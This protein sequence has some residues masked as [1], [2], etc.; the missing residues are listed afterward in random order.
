MTDP[1]LPGILPGESRRRWRVRATQAGFDVSPSRPPLEPVGYSQQEPPW[2]DPVAEAARLRIHRLTT[3]QQRAARRLTVWCDH[4]KPCPL[5]GVSQTLDGLLVHPMAD[6]VDRFDLHDHRHPD[7][8]DLRA[9]SHPPAVFAEALL[10]SLSEPPEQRSLIAVCPCSCPHGW[11]AVDLLQ[12]V[13]LVQQQPETRNVRVS[14][15]RWL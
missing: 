3:K 11:R 2:R 5:V 1:Q 6:K 10:C 15:L 9:M 8:F 7:E 4:D 12:V 14:E 13:Q